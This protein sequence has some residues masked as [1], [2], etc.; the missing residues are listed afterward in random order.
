M[1]G[2]QLLKYSGYMVELVDGLCLATFGE[3]DAA[4]A[5]A[6]SCQAALLSAHWTPLV[7]KHEL[8]EEM[9][10]VVPPNSPQE[11]PQSRVL[12]RCLG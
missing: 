4:V 2:A 3:P 11:Q 9:R 10:V 1:V 6:L 7:L 8:C 12:C 5:W